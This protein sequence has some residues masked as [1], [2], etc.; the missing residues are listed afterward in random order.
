[1]K[2]YYVYEI[3]DLQGKVLDVGETARTVEDRLREKTQPKNGKF[4]GRDDLCVRSVAEFMDR[5]KALKL[6]GE[7]KLQYGLEWTENTRLLGFDKKLAGEASAKKSRKLSFEEVEE[8]KLLYASKL[9]NQYTLASRFNVSRSNI[10]AILNGRTY[11]QK[12][13]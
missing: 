4:P 3:Y 13:D 12:K 10:Q 1:M 2:K 8:I 7:L 9:E 6:E 5:K 11:K